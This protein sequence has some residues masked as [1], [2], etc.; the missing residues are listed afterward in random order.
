M[1]ARILLFSSWLLVASGAASAQITVAGG[2]L[3]QSSVAPGALISIFGSGLA[4]S[5]AVAS[6]A[7]LSTTL[8]DVQSVTVNGVSAPILSISANQITAQV[9]WEVTA[10][11]ANVMVTNG[12]GA[13]GPA[14]VQV[15]QY[16]P[17]LMALGGWTPQ[18]LALNADG[19]FTA[20]AML[21]P[22]ATAH[23]AT[24]GDTIALYATGLGPLDQAPPPDGFSSSDMARNTSSPVSVTMGG[25]PATVVSAVLSPQYVGVYQ[26]NVTVP[27][28]VTGA[29]VGLQLS[30][31]GAQSPAN[32]A[33]IAL[34]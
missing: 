12:G 19:S 1:R 6:S 10:G 16:A 2:G 32:T 33:T 26:I 22:G 23:P 17:A 13:L 7:T 27:P 21:I 29:A 20:P 11:S 31:G 14:N 30:I 15:S 34:Q 8:G 3:G 24:A 5:L 28:G 9:P 4:S 25:M 18:A